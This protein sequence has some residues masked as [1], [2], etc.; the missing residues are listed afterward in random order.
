M[1]G[2]V[3]YQ[4]ILSMKSIIKNKVYSDKNIYEENS[5]K[6]FEIIESI[7]FLSH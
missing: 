4:N 6:L 5:L 3:K 2:T 7:E 1:R